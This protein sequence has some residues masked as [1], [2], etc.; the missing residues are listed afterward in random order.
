MMI[1]WPSTDTASPA[2]EEGLNCRA[3]ELARS[4]G[5]DQLKD[6]WRDGTGL[7]DRADRGPG[8]WGGR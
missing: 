8:D 7:L 3:G 2:A 6:G 4:E 1:G 5:G